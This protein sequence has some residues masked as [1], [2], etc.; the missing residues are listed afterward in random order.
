MLG[1]DLPWYLAMLPN[2]SDPPRPE[3]PLDFTEFQEKEGVVRRSSGDY[4][5]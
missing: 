5:V 1:S 4:S 2:L 3:Y